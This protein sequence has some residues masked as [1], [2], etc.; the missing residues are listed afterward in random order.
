MAHLEVHAGKDI[1]WSDSVSGA[2]WDPERVVSEERERTPIG[3]TAT[4]WMVSAGE[5]SIP[6]WIGAG[7][8]G[9]VKKSRELSGEEMVEKHGMSPCSG[10]NNGEWDACVRCSTVVHRKQ[11]GR[12]RARTVL[13]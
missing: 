4:T 6:M 7:R 10:V 1:Y 2:E 13:E 9:G 11:L 12:D 5:S 8:R 3:N